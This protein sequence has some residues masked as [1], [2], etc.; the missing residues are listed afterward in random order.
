MESPA[1]A[2]PAPA[3]LRSH[4]I[5][6]QQTC[7]RL[8]RDEHRAG[9]SDQQRCEPHQVRRVADQDIQEAPDLRWNSEISVLGLHTA[10]CRGSCATGAESSPAGKFWCSVRYLSAVMFAEQ[11]WVL[12]GEGRPLPRHL[13]PS[14]SAG[15]DAGQVMETSTYLPEDRRRRLPERPLKG[16]VPRG[17]I[18]EADRADDATQHDWHTDR[19]RLHVGQQQSTACSPCNMCTDIYSSPWCLQAPP[20]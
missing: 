19:K 6:V 16:A 17:L 5:F 4:A 18:L 12:Y 7:S 14:S 1:P 2:T 15:S 9:S 11:L 10:I 13:Q 3:S 8:L 20:R